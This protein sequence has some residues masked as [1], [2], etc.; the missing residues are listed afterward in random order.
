MQNECVSIAEY[1]LEWLNG[2]FS[3]IIYSQDKEYSIYEELFIYYNKT[4]TVSL[5]NWIHILIG[6]IMRANLVSVD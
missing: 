1:Q 2:G 4:Y 5:Q 6:M 3:L